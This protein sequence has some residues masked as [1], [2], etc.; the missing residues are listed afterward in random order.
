M[1]QYMNKNDKKYDV[2]V[3]GGGPAGMMAAIQAAKAGAKTVLLEKNETLGKKLLLT[4]GGRCNLANDEKDLRQLVA[5]YGTT[6]PFLFHAFS[7]FG[8][9]EATGFFN[10]LGIET[11]VEGNGRVFPKS[12][13]AD[14]VLRALTGELEEKKVKI[15]FGVAVEKIEKEDAKISKIILANNSTVV[16]ENYIIATGGKSYPATGS[17][18]DGYVFAHDLGHHIEKL[19]PALVPLKTAQAWAKKLSGVSLKRP[20]V[21]A[22][23]N[24]KKIFDQT[25]EVIF[26]HFGVSGPAI[27]GMSSR[28]GE[29]LENGPVALSVDLIPESNRDRLEK[30]LR[31]MFTKNPNRQLANVLAEIIPQSIAAAVGEI[32]GVA[33]EKT[34]NNVTREERQRLAAT[35]L[36]LRL[37]VTGLLEI[38]TGM[39][40]GGGVRPDE[41]DDKTMRSKIIPNLF[42]AG[43]ILN[44]HGRTGGYNLLQCWSTGRLAGASVAKK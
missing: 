1:E 9:K 17:T 5:N 18:G 4:G 20:K 8:P 41:V 34:A 28:I 33:P 44:V 22:W 23:Q 15:V 36:D 19:K 11:S 39:V 2:A 35:M 10:G 29:L 12:G 24:G 25:G 13:L 7:E 37:D 26:T 31:L 16:A 38:E 30:E 14:D 3:I 27:L 42:F 6:G 32:C 43:E 40:T 21:T